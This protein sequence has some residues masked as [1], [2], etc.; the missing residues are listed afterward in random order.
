MDEPTSKKIA[1]LAAEIMRDPTAPEEEKS[2]AGSALSLADPGRKS[3]PEL[4]DMAKKVIA[5]KSK[6]S[7]YAVELAETV[8]ANPS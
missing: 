2:L 5:E 3:S 7:Q 1:H 4:D 8:L 6:H